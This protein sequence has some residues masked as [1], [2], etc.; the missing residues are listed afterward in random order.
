MKA[1][2]HSAGAASSDNQAI[3]RSVGGL[4]TK[5][6]MAVE[7]YGLPIDFE[8]TEG[9]VHECKV[10]LDFIERLPLSTYT[11]ADRGYDKEDL[12][13]LIVE[14]T[15]IPI[16]PRKDNSRTGNSDIDW[17]LYKLRHLVENCFAR[18]KHFRIPATRYDKLKRNYASMFALACAYL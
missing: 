15:S 11:I 8:I 14:K 3:G 17:S 13:E 5:I 18:F 1:H 12:R 16:I 4:S 10:A 6:Y 7:A 9:Q 2:Q